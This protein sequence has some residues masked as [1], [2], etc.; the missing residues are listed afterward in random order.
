M[1]NNQTIMLVEDNPD[2]VMLA[3]RA[4]KIAGFNSDIVVMTDG[5]QV[6]EYLKGKS[7]HELPRVVLLDLRLPGISGLEVLKQIRSDALTRDMPVVILSTSDEMADKRE[8]YAIGAN[9]YILKPIE[10]NRFVHVI[11]RLGE[12]WL[13]LNE[14][15]A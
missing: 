6:L 15:Y 2:H 5:E 7:R 1:K 9:S 11:E 3:L 13:D 12:Y 14:S 10:F 4:L 8:G